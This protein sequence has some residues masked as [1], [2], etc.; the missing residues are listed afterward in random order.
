M[1]LLLLVLL[2]RPSLVAL[3][4]LPDGID[5]QCAE[6]NTAVLAG[7]AIEG[8]D[9]LQ[10]SSAVKPAWKRPN[11]VIPGDQMISNVLPGIVIPPILE[12]AVL[13]IRMQADMPPQVCMEPPTIHHDHLHTRWQKHIIILF[14]HS[15]GFWL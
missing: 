11:I 2:V 8:D 5:E 9:L 7:I 15:C 14:D 6:C 13:R 3:A 1:P 4:V 12:V 10:P